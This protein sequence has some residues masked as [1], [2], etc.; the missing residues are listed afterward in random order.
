[1]EVSEIDNAEAPIGDA[2]R[3]VML[4]ALLRRHPTAVVAALDIE[5]QLVALPPSIRV[6]GEHVVP[7]RSPVGLLKSRSRAEVSGS[8]E[9]VKQVGV[10]MTPVVLVNGVEA[11]CY[12][13]DLRNRH[14]VL[15]GLTVA[16]VPMGVDDAGC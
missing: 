5:G 16:D 11:S 4:A 3:E 10:S 7:T 15:V 2:G 12:L 13:I 14:G 8:W 1:V 9:R 6:A